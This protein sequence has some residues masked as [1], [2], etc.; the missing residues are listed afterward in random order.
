MIIVGR[1]LEN[2]HR[3][4]L[5][6]VMEPTDLQDLHRA[7]V[8]Q[9]GVWPLGEKRI[10][11]DAILDELGRRVDFLLK[12]DFER[13]MSCMYMIDVSEQRFSEAVKSPEGDRPARAIAELILE[14][15]V[16]KMES[17]R[18]YT[19]T[20]YTRVTVRIEGRPRTAEE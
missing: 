17:R 9:W 11:W 2:P 10:A 8:Q 4:W 7:L 20:E 5:N 16:E 3:I 6:A 12:H 1:D 14:R 19:R 15:E 13:L 18:R